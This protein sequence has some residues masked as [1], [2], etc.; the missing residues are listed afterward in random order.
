MEPDKD[1]EDLNINLEDQ[2]GPLR[3]WISLDATSRTIEKFF[4]NFLLTFADKKGVKIYKQRIQ[5]MCSSNQESLLVNYAH[6]TVDQPTLSVYLADAPA[7]MLAIFDRVAMQQVLVMFPHYK[8]IH[9]EIH[10][11]VT[12]LPLTDSLRE[13]LFCFVGTFFKYFLLV[14][15]TAPQSINQNHWCCYK[16]YFCISSVEIRE[17]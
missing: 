6:L 11:R 15:T 12:H 9:D 13:V 1:L 4:R 17:I 10:V 16:A 5:T 7:E 3:E 8:H 2:K 14:A